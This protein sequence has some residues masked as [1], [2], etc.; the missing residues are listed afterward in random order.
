ML[1]SRDKY[2]CSS[3]QFCSCSPNTSKTTKIFQINEGMSK[4]CPLQMK[5]VMGLWVHIYEQ[6][7]LLNLRSLDVVLLSCVSKR[8]RKALDCVLIVFQ[9]VQNEQKMKKDMIIE[10]KGGLNVFFL[11]EQFHPLFVFLLL[12]LC[13]WSSKKYC[14]SSPWSSTQKPFVASR[15]SIQLHVDGII[16][17]NGVWNLYH[18][19]FINFHEKFLWKSSMKSFCEMLPLEV[20]IYC[21]NFYFLKMK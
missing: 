12:F 9:I 10:S 7:A 17:C 11:L 14:N 15:M 5:G 8:L 19:K 21:I 18:Y 13:F 6:F 1:K 16:T 2:L 3:K 4:I 20:S